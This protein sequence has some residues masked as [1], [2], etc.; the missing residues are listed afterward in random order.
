M[1]KKQLT[2]KEV[3]QQ[4]GVPHLLLK[5]NTHLPPMPLGEIEPAISLVVYG[6]PAPKGSKTRTRNGGMRESSKILPAWLKAVR[7]ATKESILLLGEEWEGPISEPVIL[8]TIFTFPHSN[9]SQKR[10]DI[11]YTNVP[12]LDKLQR[13][14]GDA[15]SPVPAKRGATSGMSKV[16]ADNFKK[17]YKESSARYSILANDSFIVGF[18]ESYKVYTES[19][20]ES[21]KYPGV[22]LRVWKQS[23]FI[24]HME[25]NK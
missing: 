9:A 21:L 4:A 7:E 23:D 19:T 20:P 2:T 6:M 10:G 1:S 11:Y 14:V 17:E 5:G 13:A 22:L 16:E 24:K 3:Q 8:S 25:V 12:D 15:I 18:T